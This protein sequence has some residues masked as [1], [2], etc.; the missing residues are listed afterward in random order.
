MINTPLISFSTKDGLGKPS[1][2]IHFKGCDKPNKCKGCHSPELYNPPKQKY[3]MF[4]LIY[5]VENKINF[6][7]NDFVDELSI[8]YMGGDPLTNWNIEYTYKVSK[9]IH[10]KYKLNNILYSWKTVKQIKKENLLNKVNFMDFGILG[11][12]DIE[13]KQDRQIPT[14]N[15]QYIYDFNNCKKIKSIKL[16]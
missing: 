15:N 7:L 10:E 6:Y 4:N 13:Q 1:I 3:D 5:K 8:C 9:I 14:S 2:N 16:K 11:E 12:F